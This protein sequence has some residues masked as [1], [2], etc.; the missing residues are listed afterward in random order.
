MVDRAGVEPGAQTAIGGKPVG[1]QAVELWAGGRVALGV[2]DGRCRGEDARDAG[3][4]STDVGEQ[5]RRVGEVVFQAEQPAVVIHRPALPRLGQVEAAIGRLR[6]RH[7]GLEEERTQG[8]TEL[9]R[10]REKVEPR[11]EPFALIVEGQGTDAGCLG[12]P[13]DRRVA[14]MRAA[15]ETD[16]PF[17]ALT[18]PPGN[19]ELPAAPGDGVVI[20]GDA[21]E[22]LAR[23]LRH[24]VD[25]TA[26]PAIRRHA[27]QARRRTLQHLD[28]LGII[29]ENAEGRRDAVDAVEG[30]L[31]ADPFVDGQAPDGQGIERRPRRLRRADRGVEG[32]GLRDRRGLPVAD[33]SIR[34]AGDAERRFRRLGVA[35]EA[36]APAL[37]HLPAGIGRHDTLRPRRSLH[38]QGLKGHFGRCGLRFPCIGGIGHAQDGNYAG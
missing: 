32:Q 29:G 20:E 7:A 28:P 23:P 3:L 18:A 9:V 34:V 5:R 4:G 33:E 19:I 27:R 12:L 16:A 31:A 17:A 38:R 25:D 22:V 35:E 10:L 8:G 2:G 13:V 11:P 6:H 14:A 1:F 15:D 37:R 36:E 24:D 26:D 21:G 30:D